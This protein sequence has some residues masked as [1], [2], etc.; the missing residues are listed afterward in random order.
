MHRSALCAVIACAAGEVFLS[1]CANVSVTRVTSYNQ[2]GLR[3]WRPAPYLALE[4]TS[5]SGKTTCN[6]KIV[7]LP[8]KSEEYAITMN[9][10]VGTAS[11]NPQLQDGWN[12]TGLN[13]SA[14]SKTNENITALA[15]LAK[16]LVPLAAPG[17]ASP[18]PRKTQVVRSNC[19]GLY[20]MVFDPVTGQVI[21]VRKIG[22]PGEVNLDSSGSTAPSDGSRDKG[23]K[24]A[25]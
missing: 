20:R 6:A 25:G 2:P 22:L 24:K 18:A 12:L 19:H 8:D 13:A 16:V 14:D 17:A 10:G 3:Y 1:G 9:A 15:S 5:E 23:G 7:M 21:G 4:E 11:A